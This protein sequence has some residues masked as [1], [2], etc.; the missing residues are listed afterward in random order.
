MENIEKCLQYKN[1]EE[2]D[3]IKKIFTNPQSIDRS[4]KTIVFSTPSETGTLIE[5]GVIL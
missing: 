2:R 4:K 1:A 5:N 3:V